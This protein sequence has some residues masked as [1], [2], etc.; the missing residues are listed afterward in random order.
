MHFRFHLLTVAAAL[1]IGFLPARSDALTVRGRVTDANSA[2]PIA[3][4]QLAL[5]NRSC[6]VGLCRVFVMAE[7][8]TDADGRY[9]LEL[10]NAAGSYGL[11]AT[12]AGHASAAYS[13]AQCQVPSVQECGKVAPL[14]ISAAGGEVLDWTDFSLA[15][16]A[17][18]VG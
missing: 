6:V 12:A 14:V 11:I 8:S 15:A 4:A 17:V 10:Q 9:S 2:E 5:F 16:E 1:L 13:G 18:I 3:N 7:A